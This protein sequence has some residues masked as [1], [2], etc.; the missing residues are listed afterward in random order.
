MERRFY[1]FQRDR[2]AA[3]AHTR[4]FVTDASRRLLCSTR[5][6]SLTLPNSAPK[7]LSARF[8]LALCYSELWRTRRNTKIMVRRRGREGKEA[9][10]KRW[11]KWQKQENDD[12]E[13]VTNN[14]LFSFSSVWKKGTSSPRDEVSLLPCKRQKEAKTTLSLSL[15][16]PWAMLDFTLSCCYSLEVTLEPKKRCLT[17]ATRQK[18]RRWKLRRNCHDPEKDRVSG[19]KGRGRREGEWT[20]GWVGAD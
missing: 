20:E 7:S 1:A 14:F 12:E 10:K 6:H 4:L 9:R 11:E 15:P 8:C 3:A 13:T 18:N 2:T 16:P 17:F 5:S 19:G